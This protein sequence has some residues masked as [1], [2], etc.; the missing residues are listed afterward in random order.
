YI[1][2]EDAKTALKARLEKERVDDTF[3]NARTVRDLMLNAIFTKGSKKAPSQS[4]LRFTLLNNEDFIE[5][6]EKHTED[7]IEMLQQLIGLDDLKEEMNTL[8]SFV[9]MQQFRRNHNLPQVPI[10]LHSVFSGNPGTGKTT[11]AKVY[12]Q[13]LK[14]YGILK[15]GHLIVASRADF[16]AGY[17]GQTA[18][19]TRKKIKQALGGVLFIDE[20]YSLLGQTAGDFGKEVIDTLVDEMTKH[21]EN[22]VVVLA[23]YPNEMEVLLD[24]NPGL[25]S[26]F[27]KFFAFPDYS[28][29]ELIRIMESYASKFHY[30]LTEETK[31]ILLLDL[32]DYRNKGNGRF[33]TN[34]VDE[35]M[36]AQ[37]MRLMNEPSM[38]GME[39]KACDLEAEDVTIAL[40]KIRK[41]ESECSLQQKR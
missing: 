3:G 19:K 2:A 40:S 31:N 37:A 35:M 9:K 7:P 14:E 4:L 27:K 15:R 21:N 33:A 32:K 28:V 11:V 25:R 26:R 6:D 22:L 38:E 29:E 30:R 39:E 41:G 10:Q 16:V 17:V 1:L 18:G 20:A 24:S 23:G 8:I 13:M 36:Q 5:R 12:A 34:L